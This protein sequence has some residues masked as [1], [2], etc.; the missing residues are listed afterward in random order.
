[1]LQRDGNSI[2]KKKIGAYALKMNEKE[3]LMNDF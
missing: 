2:I 1:M 3:R